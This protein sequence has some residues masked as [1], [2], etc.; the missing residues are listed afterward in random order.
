MQQRIITRARLRDFWEKYPAA[1]GPL[2][3]WEATVLRANWTCSDDVK[4]TFRT[5]NLVA[6]HWV[7]DVQRNRII[8]TVRF[9]FTKPSGAVVPTTVFI[10]HVF[11]HPE[12]DKWST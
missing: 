8:A 4:R 9:P 5:A 10:A 3:T 1:K 6:P 2:Q 12:Y 7:F 11:T